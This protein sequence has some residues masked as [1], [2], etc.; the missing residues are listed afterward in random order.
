MI[1]V[2][3]GEASGLANIEASLESMQN[4]LRVN[5]S[6]S[7]GDSDGL[8]HVYVMIIQLQMLRN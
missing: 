7:Q 4:P 3:K 8:R 5:H 6:H 2:T 1:A